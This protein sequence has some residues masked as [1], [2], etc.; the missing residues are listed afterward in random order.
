MIGTLVTRKKTRNTLSFVIPAYNEEKTL[1]EIVEKVLKVK[2]PENMK[3]ELII[4]NDCSKDRTLKIATDLAKKHPEIKALTNTTNL[5]KTP[6]VKKGILE[7]TGD[8]VIIQDADSEY[9]PG[10]VADLVELLLEENLDVVYGDRF[11]KKNKVIYV[12]NYAG[13]KFLSFVSNLFTY[14][15]IK[16][17]IPDVEVCYKLIDGPIARK[18][19][20][21]IQSDRFGLEPEITARL[22]RYKK[23][24]R[25][26]KFG[27]VPISYD[28]R[29]IAEG[30]TMRAFRDGTKAL[31]EIIYYNVFAT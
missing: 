30:K 2:L 8:L 13:N 24:G 29:T 5:G 1:E 3:K 23:R 16:V 6:S 9:D 11:G 7:T 25:H 18:I 14:P 26:L 21:H 17:W 19:A 15:R 12:H 28:A 22:S 4:I 27:V 10:E 20:P 31:V